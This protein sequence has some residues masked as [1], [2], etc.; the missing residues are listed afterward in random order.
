MQPEQRVYTK[1]GVEE[2]W[3]RHRLLE[4]STTDH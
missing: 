1:Q 3:S 4:A 2:R